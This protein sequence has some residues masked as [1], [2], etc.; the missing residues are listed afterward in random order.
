MSVVKPQKG[1]FM[2]N[3]N[4]DNVTR[5]GNGNNNNGKKPFNKKGSNPDYV[6]KKAETAAKQTESMK[7]IETA[8]NYFDSMIKENTVDGKFKMQDFIS[9]MNECG[10]SAESLK[11][12]SQ[13]NY[14]MLDL[15][16]AQIN[17]RISDYGKEIRVR[18]LV[19][20]LLTVFYAV[21]D[22]VEKLVETYD[23]LFYIANLDAEAEA[24]EES[25]E[26]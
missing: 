3:Y 26:D 11:F 8:A 2:G 12:I 9:Y 14:I 10:Y 1:C 13:L 17:N 25:V 16:N 15:A 21:K 4:R 19:E 7:I 22:K 24:T 5:R 6:A 18:Y 20:R 23:S